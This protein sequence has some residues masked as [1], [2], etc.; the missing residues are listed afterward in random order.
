MGRE[1]QHKQCFGIGLCAEK[2]INEFCIIL[3]VL[4]LSFLFTVNELVLKY[5]QKSDE[6]RLKLS[7]PVSDVEIKYT[8]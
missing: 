3:I 1:F 5:R 8:L 7:P 4:F 2:M 6:K